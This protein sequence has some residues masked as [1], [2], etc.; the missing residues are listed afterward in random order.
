MWPS[1]S[2]ADGDPASDVLA[3]QALFLPAEAG[4][5]VREQLRLAA[6]LNVA[7]HAGLPI[8]VAII[9]S[10]SDL[11]AVSGLWDRP[12]DYARFLGIELSLF[13]QDRLLAVMPDGV[14]YYHPGRSPAAVYGLLDRIPSGRSGAALVSAAQAG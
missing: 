5:P 14:G 1:P 6:L 13:G 9:S 2:R 8:R 12:R 11:G 4:I 3:N 7:S 10:P